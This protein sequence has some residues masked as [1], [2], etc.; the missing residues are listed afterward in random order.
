MENDN[1]FEYIASLRLGNITQRPSSASAACRGAS[2]GGGSCRGEE[3][4]PARQQRC[5]HF[6]SQSLTQDFPMRNCAISRSS[7]NFSTH[8]VQGGAEC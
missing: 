7:S 1:V 3:K 6:Y 4:K 8:R 2:R 5:M